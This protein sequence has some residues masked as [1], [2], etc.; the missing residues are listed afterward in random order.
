M[1]AAVVVV[2]ALGCSDSADGSGSDDTAPAVAPSVVDRT[3]AES[4]E[5]GLTNEV[6]GTIEMD[7]AGCVY[8]TSGGHRYPAV[9]PSG[10]STRGDGTIIVEGTEVSVGEGIVALGGFFSPAELDD[11]ETP[12]VTLPDECLSGEEIVVFSSSGDFTT[13]S[14]S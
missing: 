2:S 14:G 12:E 9:W 5:D 10:T 6:T 3:S 1:L 4:E 8:L 7:D 11:L 13:T